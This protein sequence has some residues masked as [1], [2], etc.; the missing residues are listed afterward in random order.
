MPFVGGFLKVSKEKKKPGIG[1]QVGT[2]G[3][4]FGGLAH[5]APKMMDAKAIGAIEKD[6]AKGM[7]HSKV[8]MRG[9]GRNLLRVGPHAAVGYIGG[10]YVG[11]GVDKLLHKKKD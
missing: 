7:S 3:G 11:R 6:M 5:G 1:E 8:M 10:K 2:V 9:L 4:Y